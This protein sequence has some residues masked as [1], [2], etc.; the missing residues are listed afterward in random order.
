MLC[1]VFGARTRWAGT[2]TRSEPR[3][4]RICEPS[5]ISILCKEL[6]YAERGEPGALAWWS[7]HAHITR[8][9]V[10]NRRERSNGSCRRHALSPFTPQAGEPH[11]PCHGAKSLRCR[12]RSLPL[13]NRILFRSPPQK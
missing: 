9:C 5:Y 12:R 11:R 8:T 3:I 6:T 10:R 13:K 2:V 4:T 1:K 7:T